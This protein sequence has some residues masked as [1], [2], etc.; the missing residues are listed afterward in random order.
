MTET[1]DALLRAIRSLER[2]EIEL[3]RAEAVFEQ[4]R[5]ANAGTRYWAAR[6]KVYRI[7]HILR[8]ARAMGEG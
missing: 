4:P 7:A 3:R 1:I 8:G 6:Q 2:A 5:L